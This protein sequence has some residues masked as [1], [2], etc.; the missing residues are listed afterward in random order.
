M[1]VQQK[2]ALYTLFCSIVYFIV[3]LFVPCLFTAIS[4]EAVLLIFLMFILSLWLIRK[5]SGCKYREM[6]E[7]DRT[8]RL[9]SA[10]IATHAFGLTVALYAIVLYLLHRGQGSAPVHQ[11]LLLALHSWL[12]LY[13]FW[14]AS[15]LILYKKGALNV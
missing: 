11:V 3:L 9:Q 12:S 13:A 14:S 6:D 10:I 8:I 5:S 1:S 15:I 2:E 4:S 7:M